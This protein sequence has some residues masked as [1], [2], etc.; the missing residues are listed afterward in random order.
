MIQFFEGLE[1][2][3]FIS[4]FGSTGYLYNTASVL[5]YFCVFVMVGSMALVDLRVLGVAAKR[6]T[7]S[8]LADQLF[9]WMWTAFT[10]A[11]ISGFF[12]SSCQRA[13]SFSGFAPISNED[14]V[15]RFGGGLRDHRPVGREEVE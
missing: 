7:I 10:I 15:Y 12:W 2:N 8:Q 5:H 4:F 13:A 1:G 9:P 14:S 3:P 11:T 6:T